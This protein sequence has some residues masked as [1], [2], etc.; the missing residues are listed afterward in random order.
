MQFEKGEAFCFYLNLLACW[1]TFSKQYC[2]FL[3]H[4]EMHMYHQMIVYSFDM[5]WF[6]TW[7]HLS[8]ASPP[9]SQ[10]T[11]ASTTWSCDCGSA[12]T[13]ACSVSSWWPPTPAT[14]SSTWRASQR[15]AFPASS[16][17]SSSPTPSRRWLAPSNTTPSTLTSS[18]TTSR[19]T[20]ASVWPQTRVSSPLGWGDYL[21]RGS[22]AG[23]D[24]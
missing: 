9:A 19:P 15:R 1:F 22:V 4:F 5:C 3:P 18:L 11:T 24:I 12:S 2:K 23:S 7:P 8:H 16:P 6:Y 21:Q 20:S 10:G 17:L 14:S 13:P